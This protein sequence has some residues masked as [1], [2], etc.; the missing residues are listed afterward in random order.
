MAL[1]TTTNIPRRQWVSQ[2][3]FSDHAIPPVN[4]KTNIKSTESKIDGNHL[5]NDSSYGHGNDHNNDSHQHNKRRF[6]SRLS[7]CKLNRKRVLLCTIAISIV[8]FNGLQLKFSGLPTRLQSFYANSYMGNT[9]QSLRDRNLSGCGQLTAEQ[10]RSLQTR[11]LSGCGKNSYISFDE[12]ESLLN[13]DRDKPDTD[14]VTEPTHITLCRELISRN[15]EV[16]DTPTNPFF[17]SNRITKYGLLEVHETKEDCTDWKR[18]HSTLMQIISSSI[19]AYV[20]QPFS[21][22]YS[23]NCH[24]TI[25][26]NPDLEF[27]V[28]TAQQVFTQTPI[29]LDENILSLQDVVY[30]LCQNCVDQ[31]N[32]PVLIQKRKYMKERH[33]EDTHHCFL[34]PDKGDVHTGFVVQQEGDTP[35]EEILDVDDKIVHTA[36]EAVLPLVRNR[37]WHVSVDWS[38]NAHIPARDPK[39]GAVI[40]LDATQSVPI[41]FH[42]F[43][44]HVPKGVTHLSII[45]SPACAKSTLTN[46]SCYIYGLELKEYL[47]A[48]LT[49]IEVSFDLVSS[50][51][52]AYSRMIQTHTLLCPPGTTTC[53]LPAL[54]RESTKDTIIFESDNQDDQ[55]STFHWFKTLAVSKFSSTSISVVPIALSAI[56]Q[57]DAK[58]DR[59]EMRFQ[60]D[61]PGE[62]V[63]F[64]GEQ[65]SNPGTTLSDQHNVDSI[66]K[67]DRSFNSV[68]STQGFSSKNTDMSRAKVGEMDFGGDGSSNSGISL[69]DQQRVSSKDTTDK[70]FSTVYSLQDMD[71]VNNQGRPKVG[72]EMDFDGDGSSNSG[73]SLFDQQR[74][75][76]KDTMDK[77]FNSVYSLQDMNQVNTQGRPVYD[78]LQISDPVKS[79]TSAEENKEQENRN[80]SGSQKRFRVKKSEVSFPDKGEIGMPH[81]D[82][83][84]ISNPAK[85]ST[86]GSDENKV[87]LSNQGEVSFP[88]H[89]K[90]VSSVST[91]TEESDFKERARRREE[92]KTNMSS[93]TKDVEDMPSPEELN[94]NTAELFGG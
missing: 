64:D 86:I 66:G 74:A 92:D 56:L 46:K 3:D 2:Y 43:H 87:S 42:F 85:S 22:K 80:V 7:Q 38:P 39:A 91:T 26:A 27:D 70:A 58:Q 76:S 89:I 73:T 4:T 18:P 48:E 77:A 55:P 16:Q 54:A 40:Y 23:H 41:P 44:T 17:N 8:T 29:T 78:N 75:S 65:S 68:H 6:A 10:Q 57:T 34:F 28:T 24:S 71:Q 31:E 33:I 59:V 88:E 94:L 30:E 21:L 45:T 61:S 13:R 83:Q 9:Q 14:S 15:S 84:Q 93:Y 25:S 52:T 63:K 53:L 67:V 49:E 51:A 79:T 32:D 47:E 72:E 5:Q 81:Y 12:A 11:N 35:T 50:T 37:L 69:S 19:V 62:V 1:S 20:G 90:K 36:L 82:N 60:S